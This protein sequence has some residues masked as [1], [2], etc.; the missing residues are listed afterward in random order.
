MDLKKN[1]LDQLEYDLGPGES[2]TR[3]QQKEREFLDDIIQNLHTLWPSSIKKVTSIKSDVA[4]GGLEG[5][6]YFQLEKEFYGTGEKRLFTGAVRAFVDSYWTVDTTTVLGVEIAIGLPQRD[7]RCHFYG[8]DWASTIGVPNERFYSFW[9]LSPALFH[10][11][12]LVQETTG[13]AL[14]SIYQKN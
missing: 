1:E 10:H 11:G 9:L 7:Y 6:Y 12:D 13:W 14:Y 4:V 8:P 2:L 3:D 5:L